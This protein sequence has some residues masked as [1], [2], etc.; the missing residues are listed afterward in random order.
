M[1]SIHW[2]ERIPDQCGTERKPCSQ[3]LNHQVLMPQRGRHTWTH[4]LDRFIN[5]IKEDAHESPVRNPLSHRPKPRPK[6][7]SGESAA[8][9]TRYGPQ[10][11]TCRTRQ[12]ACLRVAAGDPP[13][14][15]SQSQRHSGSPVMN[16]G[17]RGH[18]G[19]CTSVSCLRHRLELSVVLTGPRCRVWARLSDDLSV[20]IGSQGPRCRGS[21]LAS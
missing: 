10:C 2:H 11:S 21:G 18:V 14:G 5:E 19:R 20:A 3:L 12:L 6:P 8:L 7:A 13:G 9:T 17:M 15:S 16:L 1:T 4:V